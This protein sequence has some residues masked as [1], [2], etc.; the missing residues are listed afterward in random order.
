[1]FFAK[2]TTNHRLVLSPPQSS[3]V[4]GEQ[5]RRVGKDQTVSIGFCPTSKNI[6]K[7]MRFIERSPLLEDHYS[8]QS[9]QIRMPAHDTLPSQDHS[10]ALDGLGVETHIIR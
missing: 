10:K 9:S 6:G 8:N 2:S 1:F 5:N 3:V 7:W 4:Q